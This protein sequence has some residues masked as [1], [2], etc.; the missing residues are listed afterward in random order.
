MG[1]ALNSSQTVTGVGACGSAGVCTDECVIFCVCQETVSGQLG[2]GVNMNRIYV[3]I[4]MT[5]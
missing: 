3:F 2:L 4:F 5:I 1:L